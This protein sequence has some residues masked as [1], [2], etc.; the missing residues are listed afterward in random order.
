MLQAIPLLDIRFVAEDNCLNLIVR[1]VLDFE[2]PFVEVLK[3][4][5]FGEIEDE[6]GGD[7]A[8]VVRSGDGLKG[9]LSSLNDMTMY[10]IPN[11]YLDCEIIDS[12]VLGAKLHAKCRLM[13][14]LE[15]PLGKSKQEAGFPHALIGQ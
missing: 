11:L 4:I 8:L 2:E 9:F 3:G 15:P 12:D 6:E 1:V 13:I 5:A 10:C 14:S 7:R